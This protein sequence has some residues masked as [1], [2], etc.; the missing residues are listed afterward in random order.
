MRQ[1]LAGSAFHMTHLSTIHTHARKQPVYSR[2]AGWWVA[3]CGLTGG[4]LVF[5]VFLLQ[6]QVSA[7][8]GPC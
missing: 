5:R 3:L 4:W 1:R 7:V 8:H 2:Q 6:Q